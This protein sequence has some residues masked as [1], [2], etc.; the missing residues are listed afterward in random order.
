MKRYYQ[1]NDEE[2]CYPL[3]YFHDRLIDDEREEMILKETK[4]DV[5]SGIYFCT[6][7]QECFDSTVD[8]CGLQCPDYEP[9]NGKS[10]RCR[11]LDNAMIDTGRVF[12]LTKKGLT[13]VKQ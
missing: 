4:R 7:V 2:F 3:D 13:E 11:F 5:G 12:R 10:G 8:N 1:Y 6:S 9:R